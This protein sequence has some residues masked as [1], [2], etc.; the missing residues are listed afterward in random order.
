MPTVEDL[1]NTM[2]LG[3]LIL[4]PEYDAHCPQLPKRDRRTFHIEL[5][6]LQLMGISGLLRG[7]GELTASEFHQQMIRTGFTGT[8]VTASSLF[9]NAA[10][11]IRKL[12]EH[13]DAACEAVFGS[14]ATLDGKGE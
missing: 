12:E 10:I 11:G 6:E 13:G 2:T 5:T 14:G 9:W 1:M 8:L 3:T 4:G 7:L